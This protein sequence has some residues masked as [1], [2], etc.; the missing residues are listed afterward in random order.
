M[1][2]S[3]RGFFKAAAA[4]GIAAPALASTNAAAQ[5]THGGRAYWVA[6]M[7]RV[8]RPVLENLARGRL[9]ATMP[10]EQKHGAGRETFSHLEAFGRLM[11]G[12]APWLAAQGLGGSEKSLQDEY[13]GLAHRALDLATRPT[14]STSSTKARRSSI[15]RSWRRRC[16]ARRMRCGRRYAR[17]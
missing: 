8:A 11:C 5:D 12:I 7:D 4:L 3:R 15:P 14:S 9:K 2:Q 6:Q 17:A 16:C 1:T 13:L 10:V